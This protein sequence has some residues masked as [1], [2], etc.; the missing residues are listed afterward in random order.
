MKKN[1][2][3]FIVGSKKIPYPD[4]IFDGINV[5]PEKYLISYAYKLG[6]I[7]GGLQVYDDIE[8]FENENNK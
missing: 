3:K 5:L 1:K 7:D 2:E 8:E 4:V 6:F